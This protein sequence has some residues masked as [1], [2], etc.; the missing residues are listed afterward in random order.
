[1]DFAHIEV[2]LLSSLG[3]YCKPWRREHSKSTAALC[4]RLCE[5]FG[6]DPRLGR[7]AGLGHDLLKDWPLDLQW[8]TALRAQSIPELPDSSAA[9]IRLRG[10]PQV[11]DKMIHGPAAAVYLYEKYGLDFKDISE[12][13]ALHSSAILHMSRLAKILY[14][15][16]KLEPLRPH[17]RPED[18]IALREYDL[19]ALFILSLGQVL[20]WLKSKGHSIA[21]STLDLYNAIVSA[22]NS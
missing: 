17:A 18:A 1:M 12:A 20:E 9:A 5:R 6:L 7:I 8:K 3:L 15:S 2:E 16:D 22:R 10:E 19:D 13:V 21:Q 14:I 11:G 4:D